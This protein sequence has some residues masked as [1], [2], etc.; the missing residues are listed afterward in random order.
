MAPLNWDL[1]NYVQ[2]ALSIKLQIDCTLFKMDSI[3]SSLILIFA[4]SLGLHSV[5]LGGD[6]ER[7]PPT[8]LEVL[9]EHPRR[10]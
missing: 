7:F 1:F 9:T 6:D 4:L 3:N 8:L 5:K 2:E 10:T